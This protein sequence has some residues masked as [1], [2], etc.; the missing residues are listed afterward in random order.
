MASNEPYTQEEI[1]DALAMLI[2][3]AGN[4]SAAHREL[5]AQGKRAP[6]AG[7]IQGWAEGLHWERYDELRETYMSKVEGR[8]AADMLDV[9]RRMLEASKLATEKAIERLEKNRDDDPG[10][11]ASNLARAAAQFSDKRLSLL[12]RPTSIRENRDATEILAGLIARHPGVFELADE[13]R[14]LEAGE[15]E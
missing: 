14:Q 15:A 7:T 6:A 8:T 12:G 3:Y 13:P 9:S 11:T 5:Q 10:R 2:A 4:A 1:D